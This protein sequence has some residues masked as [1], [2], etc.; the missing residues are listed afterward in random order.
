MASGYLGVM[1]SQWGEMLGTDSQIRLEG[2]EIDVCPR[3]SAELEL[4]AEALG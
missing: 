3:F 4:R 2:G 1:V